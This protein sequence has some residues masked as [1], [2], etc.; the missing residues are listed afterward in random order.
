M[1]KQTYTLELITPC[2][3]AGADPAQAEIRAPSIR[4]QLRW[5]FRVLGGFRA[6][7]P[8]SV[9][10]QEALIFGESAGDDGRAGKLTLRVTPRNL[11][12]AVKDGQELGYPNFSDP[13]FLTFP[14]QSRERNGNKTD[15][16]GRGVIT[17]GSFELSLIWRGNQSL[18]PS[19]KALMSVFANL[20][21]MGFRSRRA[22]GAVAPT[23]GQLPLND[24]QQFF[25]N[26]NAI[27]V[28]SISANSS[29][30]AISKLGGWLRRWR[31]HGRTQ[32]H[33]ANQNDQTR[34]PHNC[35]F[36]FAKR[37]HDIGYGLPEVRNLPAFRPALGLPIIQR[38]N[39]VKNWEYGR[40]SAQEPKGR[41]ASPVI[42]RP[43]KDAQGKWYALII[44][45]DA[46]QWPAGKQAYLESQPRAVSLDLYNAMKEDPQLS[47]FS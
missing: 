15:Y 36:E 13:A 2:F 17:H 23:G 44:F 45:V 33:R 9:R 35:G 42:L 7:S 8:M 29:A 1:K 5:W 26:P 19:L 12:N 4:G 38:T 25:Q 21:S 16:N 34:P 22:M 41:F 30:N 47:P 32:D 11:I 3:C 31:S 43:H 39:G 6:L 24:W 37:D 20:G 10:E 14:V 40:G 46:R 18:A 27:V 28:K